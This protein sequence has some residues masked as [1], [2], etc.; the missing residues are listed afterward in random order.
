MTHVPDPRRNEYGRGQG[1][2]LRAAEETFPLRSLQILKGYLLSEIRTP[3]TRNG[4][5]ENCTFH[6]LSGMAFPLGLLLLLKSLPPASFLLSI[7][8]F[9]PHTY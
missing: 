6:P 4:L 3:S 7:E 2:L 5:C 9:T 8:L 1:S